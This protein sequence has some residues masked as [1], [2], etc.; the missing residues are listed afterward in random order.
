MNE[1]ITIKEIAALAQVSIGTVDRVLHNRGRVSKETKEKVEKIAKDYDYKSNVNARKLKLNKAFEIAVL[2]PEADSYWQKHREGI[3]K[4]LSEFDFLNILF[5]E[6]KLND[7]TTASMNLALDKALDSSPDGMIIAPIFFDSNELLLRRIKDAEVPVILIDS[8]IEGWDGQ[9]SYIGQDAFQ[10]G[11]TAAHLI[12]HGASNNYHVA[13]I[14]FDQAD[15]V[16]K[17]LQSR[18][19][20]FESYFSSMVVKPEIRKINIERDNRTI[21]GLLSELSLIEDVRIYVPSSRIYLLNEAIEGKEFTRIVGCDLISQ[22]FEMLRDNKI[23]FIINQLP[24]NQGY[25]AIRTLY[26]KLI[27]NREVEEYQFM[28]IEIVSK[29]NLD[30]CSL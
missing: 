21:S 13:V 29:F 12:D 14:N 6:F 5:F 1:K 24:F 7:S 4:A 19:A 25:K 11:V 8:K 27:M 9:L 2:L 10:S 16:K 23:D 30:Y 15:E 17:T 28:P 20:G 18:I 22:N 3:S 26:K